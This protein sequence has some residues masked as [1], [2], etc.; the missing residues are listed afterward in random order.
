[1]NIHKNISQ[2]EYGPWAVVTGGTSGIGAAFA[3]QLA[4][5]GLNIVLV[6]RRR[7][8]LDSKSRQLAQAYGVDVRAVQADLSKSN[9]IDA[10]VEATNDIEVGLLVANAAAE[11]FGAFIKADRD[12]LNHVIQLNITSQM[13]LVYVFGQQ[14]SERGRGGIVMVSGTIG[15]G[16]APYLANYAASKAY[17]VSLGESLYYELKQKG[18]DVL[19]LS[20]GMTRTPMSDRITGI[21]FSKM[22]FPF[23]N[24]EPTAAAAL[25][26]LGKRPS[27]IPG[28]INNMMAFMG[29]HIMG[30]KA[31]VNLFGNMLKRAV[32]PE[33]I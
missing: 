9:A 33:L 5:S 13:E 17:I 6:A 25:A 22:P 14:M 21:D 8:L 27:V 24:P 7:E 23:M 19:V 20:P 15:Y 32:A 11:Q 12:N 16:P 31:S 18:V 1:M 26:A 3:N 29:K 4:E 2:E 10:V 28:R 30:R